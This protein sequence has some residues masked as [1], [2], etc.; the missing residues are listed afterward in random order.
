MFDKNYTLQSLLIAKLEMRCSF[1]SCLVL[2]EHFRFR[3]PSLFLA[4]DKLLLL[5]LAWVSAIFP[6]NRSIFKYLN[7]LNSIRPKAFGAGRPSVSYLTRILRTASQ[8]KHANLQMETYIQTHV[9]NKNETH[10]SAVKVLHYTI[11]HIK[12]L[13]LLRSSH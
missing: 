7:S 2:P 6:S 13:K 12:K 11:I 8:I 10:L 1:L 9:F 5:L 4:Q 3:L